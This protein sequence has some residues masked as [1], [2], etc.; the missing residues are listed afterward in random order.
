VQVKQGDLAGAEKSYRDSLA[1]REQ[2]VKSDLSNAEWQRDLSVSYDRVGDVQIKQGDLPGAEKSYRDSLALREQLVKSD[3][4][5]AEW[6]RDL[7]V[8]YDYVGGVQMAQGNLVGTLKS[9]RVG[10]AIR[11]ALVANGSSSV[12]LQKDLQ[13]SIGRIGDL[14]FKF[15]L[16]RDFDNALQSADQV[17]FFAP[18]EV[19]LYANRAH[20]LMFLGREDAARALY[21]RYRDEKKVLG[22]SWDTVILED[23]AEMRK[24]G[25]MNPLMDEITKL[26]AR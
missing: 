18:D 17:I 24:A 4:S 19:W 7:A 26:F 23:F 22:K 11:Q 13:F 8:S 3:S 15:I 6:Q 14:A 1:L 12:Q 20:A 2:L 9:Y 25:L 10:L 16:A 5:N 21:L